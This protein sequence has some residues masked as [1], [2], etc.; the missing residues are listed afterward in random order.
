MSHGEREE[1]KN[2]NN[3]EAYNEAHN[4]TECMLLSERGC[5]TKT[6]VSHKIG[7]CLCLVARKNEE[8]S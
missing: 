4:V 6:E 2:M 1:K 3:S 5:V 8:E 7:F